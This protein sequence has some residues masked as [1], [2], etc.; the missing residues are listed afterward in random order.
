MHPEIHYAIYRLEAA[1]REREL[2]RRMARRARPEAVV[3]MPRWR[4]VR[5]PAPLRAPRLGG[6]N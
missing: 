3:R 2:D 6:A 4:P 5:R 1:E